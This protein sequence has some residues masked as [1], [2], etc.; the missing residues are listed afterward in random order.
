MARKYMT[1]YLLTQEFQT[2]HLI[3]AYH[4]GIKLFV[5]GDHGYLVVKPASCS[6]VESK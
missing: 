2:I 4:M 6:R 1:I 3:A 5:K